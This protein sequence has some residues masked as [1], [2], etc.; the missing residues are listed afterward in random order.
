M[1]RTLDKRLRQIYYNP[2]SP[3]SYGGVDSLLRSAKAQG[4]RNLKRDR[5][6]KFLKQQE[7]YTLHKPIRRVFKRNPIIVRGIDYQWQADLADMSDI[8]NANDGFRYLLTVIDCFSKYAWAIPIKRKD[9]TSL[10]KAITTLLEL[11]NP[12][13]PI[14][15][16]TDKGKEFVNS[17]VKELL[18]RNTIKHFTTHNVETKAAMV[19]RFNRTL[20]SR[21]YRYFTAKNTNRYIDVL[22]QL[23]HGYNHA[24]HRTI[25]VRPVDVT[26]ANEKNIWHRVY[27]AHAAMLKPKESK[28]L[29]SET[30]VRIAKTK[31]GFQKGYH[32]NWSTE[33]FR[34]EDNASESLNPK[35]LY[36]IKD[37]V[38]E[39]IEGRFYPEELQ[40]ISGKSVFR[41]EKI[42]KK[43]KGETGT[44]L[45]VKW[46]GWP[47]KFNSWIAERELTKIQRDG[48]IGKRILHNVTK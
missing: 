39:R 24:V 27:G 44:E 35:R 16:Q 31:V 33:V 29:V 20:K 23:I 48:G 9:A 15:F 43:R 5:V 8:A 17:S 34:I 26:K 40:V 19:E 45:F 7:T 2:R 12:R 32:P 4:L 47:K 30:P 13:K 1:K 41:I 37:L 3:G 38:N 28:S 36:K 46:K 22:P 25:G 10:V 11:A 18:T 6:V 42:V 21:M 14:H